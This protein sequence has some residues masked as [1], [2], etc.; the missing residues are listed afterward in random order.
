[1]NKIYIIFLSI[2]LT[3]SSQADLFSKGLQGS[4]VAKK[5]KRNVTG[6]KYIVNDSPAKIIVKMGNNEELYVEG[7]DNLINIVNTYVKNNCLTVS[8]ADVSFS[9]KQPLTV[10]V[11]TNEL[12]GLKV[13]GC[14]DIVSSGKINSNKI[15]LLVDGSGDIQIANLLS[16]MLTL[17]IMGSG[18]IKIAGQAKQLTAEIMGSGDIDARMMKAQMANILVKGSGD[19][20][21]NTSNQAIVKIVGSGDVQLF[22]KPPVIKQYVSGSGVIRTY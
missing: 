21:V 15:T 7:D 14:G 8:I 6:A 9:T 18:D 1:M 17:A 16:D 10:Y 2:F 3:I 22:G 5:E 12:T 20:L 4:G 11:T 13:K 19:C